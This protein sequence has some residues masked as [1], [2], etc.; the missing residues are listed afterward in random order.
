[1]NLSRVGGPAVAQLDRLRSRGVRIALDEF[2]TGY[3]SLSV[4]ARLPVD[5]VKLDRSFSTE[6]TGPGHESGQRLLR[7]VFRLADSLGLQIVADGVETR[8]QADLLRELGCPLGQGN[9]FAAP[10]DASALPDLVA[11]GDARSA[12]ARSRHG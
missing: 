5:V 10:A 4:I 6:A 9:V 7:A 12:P 11:A 1:M 3:S 2:G 8:E